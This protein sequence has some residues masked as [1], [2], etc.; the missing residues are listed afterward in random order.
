VGGFLSQEMR[1]TLIPY[2]C[3]DIFQGCAPK[4]VL[5]KHCTSQGIRLAREIYDKANLRVL[6]GFILHKT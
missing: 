2:R 5:A 4:N 6:S 3:V 1:R